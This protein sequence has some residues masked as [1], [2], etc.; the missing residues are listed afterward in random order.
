MCLKF[1]LGSF[2]VILFDDI[3]AKNKKLAYGKS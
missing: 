3:G 2:A 1:V